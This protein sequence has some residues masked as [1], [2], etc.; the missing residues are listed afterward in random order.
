MSTD[1]VHHTRPLPN[2]PLEL[3]V[4]SRFPPGSSVLR[5]CRGSRLSTQVRSPFDCPVPPDQVPSRGL[6]VV[7]VPRVSPDV[8]DGG[9]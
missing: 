3:V 9:S 2:H 5:P 4:G 7:E 1:T 6:V 8:G